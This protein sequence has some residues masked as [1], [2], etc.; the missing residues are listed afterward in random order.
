[1]PADV[2][3]VDKKGAR[4]A[5]HIVEEAAGL[6]GEF[7]RIRSF[8]VHRG[9]RNVGCLAEWLT[10]QDSGEHVLVDL[11]SGVGLFSEQWGTG[12]TR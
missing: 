3:V 10:K 6:S 1:M 9:C 12:S 8:K 2:L 4:D 7:R 5:A 11:Y